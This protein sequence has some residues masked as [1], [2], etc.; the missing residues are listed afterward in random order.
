MKY[1]FLNFLY[2]LFLHI[3][4]DEKHEMIKKNSFFLIQMICISFYNI[5]G[6]II[7]LNRLLFFI[8]IIYDKFITCLFL[9]LHITCDEKDE[10]IK[11]NSFFLI[12]MSRICMSFYNIDG[13]IIYINRLHFFIYIIYNKFITFL[14]LFRLRSQI[15]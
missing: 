7:Y 2:F 15:S 9:F 14:F 10:V 5:D 6:Y 3:P 12:Q 11:K 8:Y 4:C 1:N 13:Y